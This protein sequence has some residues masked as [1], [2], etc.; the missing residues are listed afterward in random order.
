MCVMCFR[1]KSQNLL[2]MDF[3]VTGVCNQLIDYGVCRS[4]LVN[5]IKTYISSVFIIKD[6][7]LARQRLVMEKNLL[8]NIFHHSV[9]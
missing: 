9:H 1:N 8:A 3:N 5:E 2:Y 7:F 4:H 6:L